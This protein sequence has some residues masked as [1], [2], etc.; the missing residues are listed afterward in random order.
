MSAWPRGWV[1]QE[2][3]P[4][5]GQDAGGV[6]LR[7]LE[8][9]GVRPERSWLCHRSGL[10]RAY[11]Q[12]RGCQ[13]EKHGDD[14][15]AEGDFEEEMFPGLLALQTIQDESGRQQLWGGRNWKY[16]AGP[17]PWWAQFVLSDQDNRQKDR[18]ND[19]FIDRPTNLTFNTYPITFIFLI[20]IHEYIYIVHITFFSITASWLIDWHRLCYWRFIVLF[21]TT[22][23]IRLYQYI[24]VR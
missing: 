10:P 13:P 20:N 5:A 11:R 22:L 15:G 3:S 24:E 1:H 19:N 7:A 18:K 6:H 12:P 14:G 9:P 8:G 23:S 4:P 2:V 16:S 17:R 21:V